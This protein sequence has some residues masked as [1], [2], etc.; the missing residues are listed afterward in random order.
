MAARSNGFGRMR[1]LD[2]PRRSRSSS[3]SPPA[4]MSTKLGA[5]SGQRVRTVSQ[6]SIPETPGMLRSQRTRSNGSAASAASAASAPSTVVTANRALQALRRTGAMEFR[7]G[8]LVVKNW[9]KLTSL[10]EF[11]PRYL[12]L[13][14]QNRI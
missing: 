11:D 2:V 4:V 6:R 12:H 14:R 7:D 10:G 9:D 13:T 8:T 5:R 1:G 3:P